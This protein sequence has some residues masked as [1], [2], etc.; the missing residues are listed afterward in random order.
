MQAYPRFSYLVELD[1]SLA[2]KHNK[3][4]MASTVDPSEREA[5][6]LQTEKQKK[7]YEERKKGRK[8]K[9]SKS[10]KA[11]GWFT[12]AKFRHDPRFSIDN[13]IKEVDC[14]GNGSEDDLNEL[15]SSFKSRVDRCRVIFFLTPLTLSIQFLQAG[16]FLGR[17]FD[18]TKPLWE[19]LVVRNIKDSAEGTQ[20][21]LLI[22]VHHTLSDGQGQWVKNL[23]EIL[24]KPD[25]HLVS[26]FFLSIFTGMI[27]AY[28]TV[29]TAMATGKP[30]PQVQAKFDAA[31]AGR[32]SGKVDEKTESKA[33]EN[34][35]SIGE[36]GTKPTAW[37]TTKHSFHTLRGLYFSSR[38]TFEYSNKSAPRAAGRLYSQSQGILMSDIKLIRKAFS[39]EQMKLTL[40]DVA[41]AVLTRGMRIAAE[42]TESKKGRKVR[43]KR[44]AIFIPISVRPKGDWTLNNFTTGGIAWFRFTDPTKENS[45]E[46]LLSQVNREMNRIKQSHV[47]KI[48]YS[49]FGSVCKNRF[50]YLPNYPLFKGIFNKAYREYSVAT[51]VPGPNQPVKFGEHEAHSYHVLPPSSPGKSTMAIG[52]ISYGGHFSVAVSVDDVPEFKSLPKEICQAFQDSAA[53]LVQAAKKRSGKEK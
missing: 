12:P 25:S 17:H 29:L 18:Y 43:D 6:S 10:L 5:E 30:V 49:W 34:T 2:S 3:E 35:K 22:K 9:Y 46:E 19:A 1:P 52:M 47:P 48:W 53:E 50:F 7:E 41:C 23:A 11:G 14:L 45:Y 13:Q 32:R 16:K 51:N 24:P 42:R 28:H 40:N 31:S 21:A 36:R 4:A 15:V 26:S 33:P 39:T 44:L 20:S 37:G 27:A 8:T 38:S